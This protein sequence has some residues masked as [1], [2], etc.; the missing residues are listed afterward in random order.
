MP[1]MSPPTLTQSRPRHSA[2]PLKVLGDLQLAPGRAHEICGPARHFGAMLVARATRGPIF[3]IAPAWDHA[4]LNG[5]GLVPFTEP[6]RLS[7]LTPNRADDLL[8]SMEEALRA[9]CVPL[10]IADLPAPPA[11]TPV[12]RLHLAAETGGGAA[13]GLLLTP[14]DG[15][16]AGVESR[17]HLAPRHRATHRTWALERRRARSAPPKSWAI[18]HT[19]QGFTLSSA[20]IAES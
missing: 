6:G 9:G 20:K 19:M 10:V 12:R 18:E 5:D 17:W 11:L 8:W 13:L 4:R 16:A 1:P 3:W 2:P 15:G 14:G 7:F